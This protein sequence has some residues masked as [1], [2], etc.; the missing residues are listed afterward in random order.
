MK[1]IVS[2]IQPYRKIQGILIFLCIG[3]LYSCNTTESKKDSTIKIVYDVPETI[4]A[5]NLYIS[6]YPNKKIIPI[7]FS[8]S[9]QISN[10]DIII[11]N[12]STIDN[13]LF[14]LNTV[15]EKYT[16][17]STIIQ[18]TMDNMHLLSFSVP[19]LII[20]KSSKR[21]PATTNARISLS[22]LQTL[23][24]NN[25]ILSDNTLSIFGFVPEMSDV[26]RQLFSSEEAYNNWIAQSFEDYQK[27]T[28]LYR[29]NFTPVPYIAQL[30]N[31]NIIYKLV[32]SNFFF[33]LPINIQ[34]EFHYFLLTLQNG[35]IKIISSSYIGIGKNTQL[36]NE[37]KHF[38]TWLF[39]TAT[40]SVLLEKQKEFFPQKN[41]QRILGNTFS[42]NWNINIQIFSEHKWLWENQPLLQQLQF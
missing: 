25:T 23:A 7:Q 16:I 35:N 28:S 10:S 19:L 13:S 37:A 20:K 9:T 14:T 21:L 40:Q 26:F 31:D 41:F 39:Q 3:F 32:S 33:H 8:N 24:K 27:L 34:D 30:Q 6:Q 17:E 29:K 4:F 2:Y 15:T 38:I 18:Q 42:T 11:L 36:K 5:I 12:K 22:I 1:Y